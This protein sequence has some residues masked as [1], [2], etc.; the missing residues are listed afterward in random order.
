MDAA[1]GGVGSGSSNDLPWASVFDS[2]A[3]L[4]A[5][6]AI[7]AEGFRAASELVDR[8]VR[9]A[10]TGIG[11]N[12]RQAQAV[13]VPAAEDRADLFGATG[14]EPFVA[15]WWLLVDQFLNLS[16]PL[17]E[18]RPS[19]EEATMDLAAATASG[20]VRLELAPPGVATAEMC[21]R[22]SQYVDLGNIRLRCGGLLAH[23]GAQIGA[24][25]VRFEPEIVPMPGR[26]SRGVMVQIELGCGAVPGTYRGMVL[27][28]GHPDVWLP[29]VLVVQ[30]GVP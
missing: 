5:L 18:Q 20:G 17:R 7:Q 27:A 28:D 4:R 22:N 1:G 19:G 25:R 10:S 15:S 13:T 16:S 6:S 24:D 9:M 11:A 3:N 8:F 21:L 29:V 23:D 12:G 14:L 2:A 26:S 30:V